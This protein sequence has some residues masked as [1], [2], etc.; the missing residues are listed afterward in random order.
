MH[1]NGYLFA[2]KCYNFGHAGTERVF[3]SSLPKC[4]PFK[5][6]DFYFLFAL[7]SVN[8]CGFCWFGEGDLG[9][10]GSWL[11]IFDFVRASCL[12]CDFYKKKMHWRILAGFK[13]KY[14]HLCMSCAECNLVFYFSLLLKNNLDFVFLCFP[15]KSVFLLEH[16][17]R[18]PYR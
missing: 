2:V 1:S 18:T 9:M 3:G 5:W 4:Q 8:F 13:K 7:V 6:L 10:C 16:V 11:L 17:D 14:T 15:N 12:P